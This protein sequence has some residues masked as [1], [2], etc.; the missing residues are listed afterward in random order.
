M[1]EE[2]ETPPPAQPPRP[3]QRPRG[4]LF[5]ARPGTGTL[6][7]PQSRWVWGAAGLGL[8]LLLLAI[9]GPW[10]AGDMALRRLNAQGESLSAEQ[11]RRE[12]VATNLRTLEAIGE[13]EILLRLTPDTLTQTFAG[14]Q[15]MLNA[16]PGGNPSNV[17]VAE[18]RVTPDNGVL[19]VTA[20]VSA[21]T[22]EGITLRGRVWGIA[23]PTAAGR[24]IEVRVAF[25]R[26]V[27][28]DVD[29]P[30][31]HWLPGGI[32]RVANPAIAGLLERINALVPVQR[33]SLLPA[34]AAAREVD[35]GSRKLA[36]P[37]V[38]PLPAAVMVDRTG[39]NVLAQ[40]LAPPAPPPRAAATVG[41]VAAAV[42]AAT[43]ARNSDAAA[44]PPTQAPPAVLGPPSASVLAERFRT[45][46]LRSFPGFDDFPNGLYVAD[47]VLDRFLGSYRVPGTL[48]ALA[49]AAIGVNAATVNELRGPDVVLRI[50]PEEALSLLAQG[51]ADA[52]KQANRDG[53]EISDV[54][55]G[56][57]DGMMTVR[58]V[59]SSRANLG[60]GRE[61]RILW[62]AAVAVAVAGRGP[63]PAAALPPGGTPAPVA[64]PGPLGTPAA[65][66]PNAAGVRLLPRVAELRM[67]RAEISGGS[68]DLSG[69][70]EVVNTLLNSARNALNAAM[71]PVDIDLPIA[72]PATVNLQ[73]APAEGFT[74]RV[75]PASFAPPRPRV[76]RAVAHFSPRGVWILADISAEG[77]PTRPAI[78]TAIPNPA[79]AT[80]T[81][82]EAAIEG[83]VRHYFGELPA[84]KIYALTPWRRFADFF[85]LAW[86]T[87]QPRLRIIGDTGEKAFPSHEVKLSSYAEFTCQLA[88]CTMASCTARTCP[89]GSCQ[90]G[91]CP[92]SCP[93]VRACT[94]WPWPARG[95]SCVDTGVPEPGCVAGVAACVASRAAS[96]ANCQREA[97]Q[98][99]ATCM[100]QSALE[101]SRCNATA[102]ADVATCNAGRVVQYGSC[103]I[104]RNIANGAASLGP[105]G[106]ISGD[107]RVRADLWIDLRYL[108]LDPETPRALARP[109][110]TGEVRGSLGLDWLPKGI[111]GHILS[112]PTRGRLAMETT[113]RFVRDYMDLEATVLGEG[114]G[115]PDDGNAATVDLGIRIPGFRVPVE[116]PTGLLN[117]LFMQ[118]PQIVVTCPVVG[119]VMVVGMAMGNTFRVITESD[120]AAAIA[121]TAAPLPTAAV[122]YVNQSMDDSNR[123]TMGAL[124]GGRFNI[125]VAEQTL[126]LHVPEQSVTVLGDNRIMRPSLVANT[127]RFVVKP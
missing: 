79:E 7:R 93:T 71:P 124:F 78:G 8:V 117:A 47:R 74:V 76:E 105:I 68:P 118:N 95:R 59:V 56:L 49:Q 82:V 73:P 27:L 87:L 30:G 116:M 11:V 91:N 9:V 33:S 53:I 42:Q 14:V 94:D 84:D 113:A 92:S 29:V 120:L 52:V 108:R 114:G 22:P 12:S 110:T 127:F 70:V 77:M 75:E 61:I 13:G 1:P 86:G 72:I 89:T 21:P 58:A 64:N 90:P 41:A 43:A 97:G 109:L 3:A 48:E 28:D 40:V 54:T 23:T 66:E 85:N 55:P 119:S 39:V 46:A 125:P 104:Q 80:A 32:V 100:T 122:F 96:Y 107:T 83:I 18:M 36:I 103:E 88:P 67:E 60:D 10:I 102:T 98:A 51:I 63:T 57:Q 69:L 44:A 45:K 31:W 115:G 15:Q 112:C 62:R 37:A 50:A 123:A 5:S 16:A 2:T 126:P 81:D 38:A 24:D 17:Q 6:A 25:Q 4:Q 121:A 101:L 106:E 34:A 26:I 35:V 19:E 65:A 99:L 111:A 20:Q